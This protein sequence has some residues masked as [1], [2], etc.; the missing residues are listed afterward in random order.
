MTLNILVVG[1]LSRVDLEE[2]YVELG[3]YVQLSEPYLIKSPN[4]WSNTPRI[5]TN[6]DLVLLFEGMWE[7]WRVLKEVKVPLVV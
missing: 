7:E 4:D 1:A 3:P 5:A 6:Y 2:L